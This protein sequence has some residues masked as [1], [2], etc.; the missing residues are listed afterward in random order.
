[1]LITT[2]SLSDIK[3]HD[4]QVCVYSISTGIL[5]DFRMFTKL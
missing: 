4:V 3:N 1:M 5:K 2:S